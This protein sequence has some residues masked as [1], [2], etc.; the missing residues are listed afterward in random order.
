[1]TFRYMTHSYAKNKSL[2]ATMKIKVTA[3]TINIINHSSKCKQ[4]CILYNPAIELLF[5]HFVFN[6]IKCVTPFH[7]IHSNKPNRKQSAAS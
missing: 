6:I 3:I 4:V 1:M 5:F 7:F 2:F